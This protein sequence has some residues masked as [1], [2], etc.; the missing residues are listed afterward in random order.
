MGPCSVLWDT[1]LVSLESDLVSERSF[2]YFFLGLLRSYLP[3]YSYLVFEVGLCK[4][5]RMRER[6][7]ANQF[8]LVII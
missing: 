8:S 6:S 2:L 7:R 3:C 5:Q 4:G 1:D